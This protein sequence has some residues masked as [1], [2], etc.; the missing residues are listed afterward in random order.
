[1]STDVAVA[2]YRD[3]RVS[4]L[5]RALLLM[6]RVWGPA[7]LVIVVNT[8]VQAGLT[9]IN[10]Q[11][12]FTVAFLVAVIVSAASALLLYAVLTA[13]ALRATEIA[14]GSVTATVRANLGLFTV[15]A[16]VQWLLVLA[17]AVIHPVAVLIVA[18]ATPFLPIAAMDGKR[19]ALGANIRA[20]GAKFGRWLVTTLILVVAAF[21]LYLLAA[22]NTF[23]IKGTPASIFFWLAIGLIAWWILTAWTLVYRSAQ[24]D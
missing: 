9:Y 1:M 11:S 14:P 10:T 7:V 5:L 2:A 18:A 12:G 23:F 6:W 8:I 3:Y 16:L 24:K 17:A 13:C 21:V 19:N 4:A 20:L 22:V 15:W